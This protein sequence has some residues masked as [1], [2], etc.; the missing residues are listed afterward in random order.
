[1][2]LKRGFY[3]LICSLLLINF[4]SCLNSENDDNNVVLSKDSQITS[5]RLSNLRM[6]ILAS[7]YFTIDQRQNLVHNEDSLP[8][9][10]NIDLNALLTYTTGSGYTGN[11]QFSIDNDSII[12]VSSGDSISL[13]EFVKAGEFKIAAPD[14]E[15]TKTYTFK[16]NI[17]QVDPDS[18]QYHL[19]STMDF[20][21][22]DEIRKTVTMDD[23]SYLTYTQSSDGIKMYLSSDLKTWNEQSLSGL[24]SD[25]EIENIQVLNNTVYV[26][27]SDKKIYL[28]PDGAN[29]STVNTTVPVDAILGYLNSEKRKGLAVVFEKD[30]VP[31]N[32]FI[33]NPSSGETLVEL[34]DEL[35]TGFPLHNITLVSLNEKT[36]IIIENMNS[37]WST[38]DGLYWVKLEEPNYSYPEITGGSIVV[39]NDKIYFIGGRLLE[40]DYNKIIY[41]S[42]NGGLVWEEESTKTQ[43]PEN[44]I[45]REGASVVLNKTDKSFYIIGG[46]NA[47]VSDSPFN[48][49]WRV[50]LNS[51]TFLK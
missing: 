33:F 23:S 49:I 27:G 40:G 31:V 29:W 18:M 12:W 35:P 22:S 48:D 5:L 37:V 42:R 28:S 14:G 16:L 13:S 7:T 11:M 4:S 20:A 3:I 24:P 26:V 46:K 21:P 19:W 44:F 34:G 51:K 50:T 41:T 10:T 36:A 15:H 25:T 39:Y 8:F 17:H 32:G 1:M 9:Q 2:Y 43:A 38:N 6:P 30:G 45:L 47:E